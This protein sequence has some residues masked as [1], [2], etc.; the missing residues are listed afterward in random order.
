M[1]FTA[2][3]YEMLQSFYSINRIPLF[4]YDQELQ[5]KASFLTAGSAVIQGKITKY[6]SD[7]IFQIHQKDYD[8]LC[9][10]NELYFIFSFPYN[11]EKYYCLGG[12]M[13]FSELL[14]PMSMHALSFSNFFNTKELELLADV[15][16]VVSLPFFSSCLRMTMLF[17]NKEAPELE[18]IS[19]YRL[20]HIK[21]QM[22]GV[23][24][25]ELFENREI[26]R[27]HTSYRQEL[28]VLHCV[29][30]GNV[31]LLEATYRSLPGIRYGNMSSTPL[32][33]L[34]YGSIA[35][36]TLV[37]RYA[38]E[39]GMEEE[40][41]FTL[42]DVYIRRMEKCRTLYELNALNER[43]AIDFT[44]HVAN[45]QQA[46]RTYSPPVTCCINQILLNLHHKISLTELSREA[47][48]TP[49]Y[50][51]YLFHKETGTKLSTFIEEKRIEEAKNLLAFTQYPLN[52]ISEY[53]SF[54]SQSYFISVFKRKTGMTP[55]GY[56]NSFSIKSE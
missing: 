24:T 7:F 13:F 30:Q 19:S 36:T 16:P 49:K 17:L 38:I 21:Y 12:P 28:A 25:S 31:A 42:S 14:V 43:M 5:L 56:R 37:T 55:K 15:L 54:T 4:L 53:L 8:I 27:S 47:G 9:Q 46:A 6:I 44:E 1:L 20:S 3:E 45:A 2:Y 34:F 40:A 52:R 35:N 41:A 51:S 50:L 48:L 22:K 23:F 26:I 32:R 39:G 10:D 29:R 11:Q 33:Q 18:A